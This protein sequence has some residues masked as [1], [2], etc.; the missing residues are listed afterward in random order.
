MADINKGKI[1][2]SEKEV[3]E[4]REARL[5]HIVHGNDEL[6]DFALSLISRIEQVR[7]KEQILASREGGL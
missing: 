4:E 3:T 1:C 2:K 7:K 6:I 5:L